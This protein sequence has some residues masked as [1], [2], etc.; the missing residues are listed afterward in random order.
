L[1]NNSD[2]R[3]QNAEVR[4]VL[5]KLQENLGAAWKLITDVLNKLG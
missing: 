4:S 3:L 5:I 1:V 2:P